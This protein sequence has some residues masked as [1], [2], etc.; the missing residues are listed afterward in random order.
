MIFYNI[1]SFVSIR[2]IL[3]VL[4]Q[5]SLVAKTHV[6]VAPSEKMPIAIDCS[7]TLIAYL[8]TFIESMATVGEGEDTPFSI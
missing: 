1:V 6:T 4:D 7:G 3:V 2:N 5:W 8:R